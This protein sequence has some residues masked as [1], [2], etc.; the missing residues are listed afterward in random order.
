MH[1]YRRQIG[2]I[3]VLIVAVLAGSFAL[4]GNNPARVQAGG[5]WSAW[6]YNYDTG[7]MIHVFPDGAAA[8]E[9]MFPLPPGTSQ[10]PSSLTISRDGSLLAAC[11][12]DDAGN[13]SVRVYDIY[14]GYWVAA[15]TP[16]A[17]IIGCGLS[18]YSFSED[19]TQ[20]A[21]GIL[22][23]YP[24]DPDARPAWEMVV[25]QMNTNAIL[26][27]IDSNAPQI[28]GLGQD[29]SGMMPFVSTF[30][31]ATGTFPGLITFKLVRWGTEGSCDYPN[32]TWN[33]SMA[34]I[35]QSDVYGKGGLSVLLPNSELTWTD[36][37]ASLPQGQLM[38]PG[39]PYNVIKYANKTGANYPI[40]SNGTV[41][42]GS[43]FVDDGRR[44]AF[45]SLV[46]DTIQWLTIDRSGV[47]TTMPA[48]IQSYELWGTLNGYVFLNTNTL[49][50]QS[51]VPE[52]RYHTFSGGQL[53]Q[54]YVAWTG[55]PGEYWRIIWVNPLSGGL[56][57]P[58]F[59][60]MAVLGTP[61]VMPVPTPFPTLPAPPAP[62]GVLAIGARA[63][64]N[65]TA[66][67]FLRVRTG[68]GVGF[69]VAFQLANGTQ[70]T[71]L[72]GPVSADGYAW[73]RVQADDGRSG[74]SV[75]GVTDTTGYLQTLV[76]LR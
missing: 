50:G 34:S 15:Y 4:P 60:Q 69:P 19:G 24:F 54:A 49:P 40:F 51:G 9:M 57:L 45:N 72:E 5:S 56:G 76:P 10:P 42:Y 67:D 39:C 31:M 8:T 48:D 27:H 71:L 37:D 59:P 70:V 52:V 58:A 73:W 32:L 36:I 11:L 35:S 17:P 12:T 20:L 63:V 68:A 16:A 28:T 47:V 61:P 65:T 6:I 23:H 62:V 26:Y 66:G 13:P 53:P 29:F 75:E 30:Q 44:I 64:V 1:S 2:L 18:Y 55:A 38:G 41:L 43:T 3:A 74:W 22:N 7:R 21:F 25:M 46:G 33:L 14:N